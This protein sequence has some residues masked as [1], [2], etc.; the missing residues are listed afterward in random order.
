MAGERQNVRHNLNRA[1]RAW[2]KA[3]PDWVRVLA[4]KCDELGSQAR[5]AGELGYK[6]A[7]TINQVIGRTNQ[8]LR[9]DRVEANVRG[10]YMQATVTCPVLGQLSTRD[11]QDN[12]VKARTFRASN[13][14]RRALF[15]ECKVCPHREKK[16]AS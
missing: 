9:L 15:I 6:N 10:V 7:S 4:V 1:E 13:P 14:L 16:D 3:L 5:V 11:C 2:G 8:A 12:Q